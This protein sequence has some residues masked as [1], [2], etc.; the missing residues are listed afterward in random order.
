MNLIVK[1]PLYK[2][3]GIFSELWID[4]VRFGHTAE[5]PWADNHPGQ[6]CLPDGVY[7]LVPYE[8]PKHGPTFVLHNPSLGVYATAEDVPEGAVGRTYCEL[9][10]ANWP[11]QLEG[12]IATG[13]AVEE[14]PPHGWA[15]TSSRPVFEDL[16]RHLGRDRGHAITLDRLP[17]SEA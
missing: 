9:H 8:S 2:D 17:R 16:M 4:E 12:C 1:N 14:L 7:E 11:Q 13:E 6:S 3:S 5:L 15:V 10:P